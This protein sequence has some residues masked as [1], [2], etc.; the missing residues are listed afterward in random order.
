[1]ESKEVLNM[2]PGRYLDALIAENVLNWKPWI[3][4]RGEYTHFVWQ[5]HGQPE[6]YKQY[7]DWEKQKDGYTQVAGSIYDPMKHVE[8]G[9]PRFSAELNRAWEVINFLHGL[10]WASSVENDLHAYCCRFDNIQGIYKPVVAY[11]RSS[12][13]LAIC[14]A[15][16]LIACEK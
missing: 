9:L 15:A 16:L 5:K 10:G 2:K 12:A 14:R 13:P 11:G 8:D 3:V 1:M 4:K 7:R 6:P